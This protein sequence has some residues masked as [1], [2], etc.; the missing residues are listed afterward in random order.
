M[1]KS[2]LLRT[3]TKRV[4]GTSLKQN[5]NYLLFSS[6][7]LSGLG[8]VFWA[9]CARL[10]NDQQVGLA[11]VLLAVVNLIG[12][13]SLL[14]FEITIIRFLH[15]QSDKGK[16]LGAMVSVAS[17]VSVMCSIAVLLL[18]HRLL[19]Q[20]SFLNDSLLVQALFVLYSIVSV[21][22]Y[23]LESVL[24][25][26]KASMYV[27][28]KNAVFSVCKLLLPFM[29]LHAASFGIYSAWMVSLFVANIVSCILLVNKLKITPKLSL[30]VTILRPYIRYSL[31]NYIAS[32][33][34]GLP[35]ILLPV[36]IVNLFG[37]AA[38]AHYYIAMMF[39]GFL[40]T[41]SVAV[42]QSLFA[43]GSLDEQAVLQKFKES[44]RYIALLQL[45]AVVVLIGLGKVLLSVFGS[46][47]TNG[48]HSLLVLFAFASTIIA[49]NNLLRTW[50][51]L[52]LLTRQL[53]Q[54]AA[55]STALLVVL[56]YAL[57]DLGVVSVGYAWLVSQMVSLAYNA[58]SIHMHKVGAN[59]H[60]TTGTLAKDAI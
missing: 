19:P 13:I 21:A 2:N 35:L 16:L 9:I 4:H 51:K 7:L 10:Y 43:E 26:Q 54:S 60:T 46:G 24:I 55:L 52:R 8:F 40:G 33:A 37:A 41:I 49:I 45:P 30:D 50:L 58:A 59:T 27:L 18:Q 36:I 44:L 15:S 25:A 12:S 23:L 29:F 11:T 39:G 28:V 57:Q 14:G 5:S 38:S 20:M 56:I 22:S 48:A 47:Y 42:T 3:I 31:H 6:V 34:E 53:M 17:T 1:S 32:F